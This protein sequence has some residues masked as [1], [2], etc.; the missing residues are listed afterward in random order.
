MIA[1]HVAAFDSPV[2]RYWWPDDLDAMKSF[3]RTS[4][5]TNLRKGAKRYFKI[6]HVPSGEVAAW[7]SWVLPK[8]FDG[9]E[10]DPSTHG[11]TAAVVDQKN[12]EPALDVGI[13]N[14]NVQPPISGGEEDI[15]EQVKAVLSVL[16]EGSQG[17]ALADEIRAQARIHD[18]HR[19]DDILSKPFT[20][21]LPT[22]DYIWV[23]F[24]LA[25]G[26]ADLSVL[27]TSPHHQRRGLARALV[28]PVLG[29]AQAKNMPVWC[30]STPVGKGLYEKLGFVPIE[31]YDVDLSKGNKKLSGTYVVTGM[32]WS[33]KALEAP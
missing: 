6:T 30:D 13:K 1:C 32:R 23:L 21:L 29:I 15:E 17:E 31:T 11:G 3:L 27:C 8:G 25:N 12:L 10:V 4:V 2:E 18:R 19:A 16:P 5:E 26:G 7:A 9:L 33:P 20:V 24:S 22:H 28:E 14:S